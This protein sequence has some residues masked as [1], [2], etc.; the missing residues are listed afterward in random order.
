MDLGTIGM[1]ATVGGVGYWYWKDSKNKKEMTKEPESV[2]ELLNVKEVYPNGLVKRHNNTYAIVLEIQPININMKSQSE[3]NGVWLNFRTAIN[4][5]PCHVTLLVQS[6]YLD[7][8]DYIQHYTEV[9]QSVPLTPQLKASAAG[10]AEHLGGFAER[11][12]REYRSYVIV[13]FNPFKYGTEAG[14]STGNA[15]IDNLV[16]ALR[17]QKVKISHD[18]A[19]ELAENMLEEVA[20]TIYASFEPMG[21]GVARLDR[22]GVYNMIYMTLNRDLSMYQRIHDVNAAG[23]F[24]E[25]KQSL[26]PDI[27]L[28]E[29]AVAREGSAS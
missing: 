5:L 4:T 21:I 10:V 17:G 26:T 24:S 6:Q 14:I 25:F 19:F 18:E 16:A 3:K 22:V 9:S 1:L 12:T 23:S 27:A 11:K 8:N 7:M 20:D 2:Q 13:R 28:R 15:T 29:A